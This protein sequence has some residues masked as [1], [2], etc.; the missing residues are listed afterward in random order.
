MILASN[1][2]Q[3][4]KIRAPRAL[5]C[6]F[7]LGRPLGRPGDVAFQRRV[8]DAAFALLERPQGPVLEDFPEA[9]HDH[10]VPAACTLP[11]RYDASLPPAIDEAIAL[12]PAWERTY[13]KTGRTQVG[14]AIG[15]DAVPDAARRFAAIADGQDWRAAGFSSENEV[16]QVA[17]D[18]RAYYEE[19]G[20]A[21]MEHVPA[22]RA[23][24][25]WIYRSTEMGK[26]LTAAAE[27]CWK[28]DAPVKWQIRMH[29]VPTSYF[30]GWH[31]TLDA[32]K[33]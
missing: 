11:P 17:M 22:A 16:G 3:A 30:E 23:L 10:G 4:E 14:R 2:T 25:A 5:F 33:I 1:R 31:G 8:L 24:E 32:T 13:A 21:L 29:I 19:A 15:P 18:V 28:D 7:P 6:D 12:R 26:V 20:L 27:A 9:I